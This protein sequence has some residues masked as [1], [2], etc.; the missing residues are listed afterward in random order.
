MYNMIIVLNILI[1]RISITKEKLLCLIIV[2]VNM[3]KNIFN[4]EEIEKYKKYKEIQKISGLN[5]KKTSIIMKK[6]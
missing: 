1:L 4:L 2:N 6:R 5:L 3:L